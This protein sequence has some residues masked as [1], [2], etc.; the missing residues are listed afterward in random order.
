M[1]KIIVSFVISFSVMLFGCSKTS[2]HNASS[3]EATAQMNEAA[4]KSA[5][6]NTQAGSFQ[7]FSIYMDK[8]SLQ[9]HF[10]PSG[11]MPDGKC[12]LLNDTWMQDCH[13]GNTCMKIVY[14]V[15][16]SAKSQKWVGIYWQNPANNWGSQKGG[17]NL[18][19]AKKLTFWA[20]GEQGGERIEEFKVG[21]LTGDYPDSDSA[22]IG[23]V[24]LSSEW[25]QYT[26]DLRG[27]DLSYISGGFVWATNVDVN[28]QSCTFYLDDLKYE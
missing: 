16:C 19:G 7:P 24:V 10:I 28:P 22:G 11:F 13:S 15:V 4:V 12:L 21:G 6:T 14:D 20:K 5:Q 27:K 26:I 1:K 17:F 23:P 8:G 18:T 9:N 2:E 25:R 3:G